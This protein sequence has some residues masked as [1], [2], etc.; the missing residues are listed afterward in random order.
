M[1]IDLY[2]T[3]DSVVVNISLCFLD[4]IFSCAKLNRILGLYHKGFI[5]LPFIIQI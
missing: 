5:A 4:F 3:I 1:F 2:S